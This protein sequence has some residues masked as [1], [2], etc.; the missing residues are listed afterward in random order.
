MIKVKGTLVK[1]SVVT[2]IISDASVEMFGIRAGDL[3]RIHQGAILEI[4]KVFLM[5]GGILENNGIIY[6]KGG[7]LENYTG[8]LVNNG[9]IINQ[10]KGLMDM[11]HLSNY[12]ELPGVTKGIYTTWA[13]PYKNSKH[14]QYDRS[15]N[16]SNEIV[17]S[18]LL[19]AEDSYSL[20]QETLQKSSIKTGIENN[21]KI[22]NNSLITTQEN[23][24]FH[25]TSNGVIHNFGN[26]WIKK[27]AVIRNDGKILSYRKIRD[28]KKIIGN[29]PEYSKEKFSK[30]DIDLLID[31]E[32]QKHKSGN[33]GKTQLD[34]IQTSTITHEPDQI[35]NEQKQEKGFFGKLKSKFQEMSSQSVLDSCNATIK[36]KP[37]DPVNWYMRGGAL[38]D[39][40]RYCEAIESCNRAIRIKPD[41]YEARSVKAEALNCL[42]RH[43]EAIESCN[44]AI[45]I[46]PD[47]YEARYNLGKALSGLGKYE[48]AV[49]EFDK[50][51]KI[52][53]D[54]REAVEEKERASLQVKSNDTK[55]KESDDVSVEEKERASLQV[56]SNDTKT[57]GMDDIEKYQAL[58]DEAQTANISKQY[59]IAIHLFDKILDINLQEPLDN[60][61]LTV[62]WFGKG[63]AHMG[64]LQFDEAKKCFEKTILLDPDG[65]FK[66][67]VNQTM[68]LFGNIMDDAGSNKNENIRDVIKRHE[69]DLNIS[70]IKRTSKFRE[71]DLLKRLKR[72][73]NL[74]PLYD[75]WSY[76]MNSMDLTDEYVEMTNRIRKNFEIDKYVEIRRDL[77][78]L[79][80]AFPSNTETRK[81]LELLKSKQ[82]HSYR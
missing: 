3:F 80:W 54:R 70:S 31:G 51:I 59:V 11:S 8:L 24:E 63:Q 41:Y 45:R 57:K 76:K 5:Y 42:G 38:I 47:Y 81:F 7:R 71:E 32:I 4:N 65:G 1:D 44:R 17:I 64:L 18:R 49:D 46:K 66:Q 14:V 12:N 82:N 13:I 25:N 26:I 34:K 58:V 69:G 68:N 22:L 55:T 35:R 19:N 78:K 67:L 40:G 36:F 21:G 2:D 73:D 62:T 30:I 27:N 29:T 23:V 60:E 72:T 15:H 74:Q 56:K 39:L 37:N 52:K 48:K 28:D 6:N 20:T 53:P 9:L 50:A 75:E 10:S 61:I 16:I 43:G 79:L 77:E 33:M